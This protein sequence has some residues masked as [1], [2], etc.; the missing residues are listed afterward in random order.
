[1]AATAVNFQMPALKC[2]A[3][4]FLM[5]EGRLFPIFSLVALFAIRSILALMVIVE[6]MAR[7]TICR[8][9][10]VMLVD[11]A[12]DTFHRLVRPC[13]VEIRVLCVVEFCCMPACCLV[14]TAAILTQAALM[15]VILLVTIKAACCCFTN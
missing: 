2:E 9:S 15:S 11:V 3:A 12:Q 7:I 8:D 6:L 5:V 14:T 13:Q 10:L 1:M 4:G